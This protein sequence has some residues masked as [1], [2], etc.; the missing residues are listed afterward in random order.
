VRSSA[1]FSRIGQSEKRSLP[2]QI[3]RKYVK[4]IICQP[5]VN[6]RSVTNNRRLYDK[7]QIARDE[8]E[9]K[10]VYSDEAGLIV[11]ALG[12]GRNG[13]HFGT[14]D[15]VIVPYSICDGSNAPEVSEGL[16]VEVMD[17]STN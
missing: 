4:R 16:P 8:E 10:D 13:N 12:G 1:P 6:T 11:T 17:M 15:Y 2:D 5:Q 7:E 14:H 3:K 9:K